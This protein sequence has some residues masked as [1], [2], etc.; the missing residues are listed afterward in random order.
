[1]GYRFL[2]FSKIGPEVQATLTCPTKHRHGATLFTVNPR[3]SPISVAFYDAH[4]RGPTLILN[5]RLPIGGGAKSCGL[6][7]MRTDEHT[8]RQTDRR[9]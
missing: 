7:K 2:F 5:P 4:G 8:D 6:D 1:M 3:N 9:T